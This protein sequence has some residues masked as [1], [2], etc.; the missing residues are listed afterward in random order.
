M[1]ERLLNVHVGVTMPSPACRRALKTVVDALQSA[2]HDIISVDPPT[3]YEGLK[4]ASQLL[5]ADAG[6]IVTKPIR[7]GEW[8]DLGVVQAL[9]MFRVPAFV[10]RFYAWYFRHIR[11]D[12]VYAGLVESWYEKNVVEYY[13]LIAQREAYREKWFD[14]WNKE[15]Y[16][17]VLTVPSALPAVPHGG[18]KDGWRACGYTFLFNLLDYSAGVLP[19]THVDRILDAVWDFEPRNAIEA[20]SYA[21]YDADLMHGLPVGIQVVGRRLE[22]EKVLEGM[23]LIEGL[24]C[25]HGDAYK[26]LEVSP[27]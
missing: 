6:K 16:D 13:A 21:M 9:K 22:E 18:M 3:P 25:K 7:W 12:E 17:F 10:R 20:S 2:G 1:I 19:V 5:L 11:K 4:I 26:L 23:K 8:N 27:E 24:L 14:M 15:G